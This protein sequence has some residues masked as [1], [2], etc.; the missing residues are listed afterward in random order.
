MET[1]T[2]GKVHT[3]IY[4]VKSVSLIPI[5]IKNINRIFQPH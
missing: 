4:I 2:N 5:D 3:Y 1:G